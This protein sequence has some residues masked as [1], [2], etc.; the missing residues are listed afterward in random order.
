MNYLRVFLAA[1]WR[2]RFRACVYAPI[3][4]QE[5][6]KDLIFTFSL[7]ASYDSNVFGGAT[8]PSAAH[9]GIFAEGRL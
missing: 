6:G 1:C 3:P 5:L 7:G 4:E 8:G 9:H 2:R